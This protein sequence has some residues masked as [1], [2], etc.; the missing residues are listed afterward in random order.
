MGPTF[1]HLYK[2]LMESERDYWWAKYKEVMMYR[3]LKGRFYTTNAPDNDFPQYDTIEEAE[4]AATKEVRTGTLTG[5]KSPGQVGDVRY[6]VM[7]VRKVMKDEQPI[8]IVKY[9]TEV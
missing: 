7:V 6:V 3:D 8:K 9:P 5:R 2:Y 1:D 4:R